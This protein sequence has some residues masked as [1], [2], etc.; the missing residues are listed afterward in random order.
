MNSNNEQI[1]ENAIRVYNGA[2]TPQQK[3]NAINMLHNVAISVGKY[4]YSSPNMNK[5]YNILKS[6]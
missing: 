5:V 4:N 2:I 3:E 6:L 1:L